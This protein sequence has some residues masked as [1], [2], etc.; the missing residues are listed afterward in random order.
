MAAQTVAKQPSQQSLDLLNLK[1][2]CCFA[3]LCSREVP[4]A[5]WW[6]ESSLCMCIYVYTY[7]LRSSVFLCEF[8][9]ISWGGICCW[10]LISQIPAKSSY[11]S[12]YWD[13]CLCLSS[14]GMTDGHHNC[15]AF[16]CRLW[17]HVEYEYFKDFYLL[18]LRNENELNNATF[19]ISYCLGKS[20]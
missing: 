2:A 7:K 17:I 18:T 1:I 13:P 16:T 15:L 8:L 4:W 12:C 6:E 9:F 3:C 19:F 14:A 5:L 11:S 10:T 20:I